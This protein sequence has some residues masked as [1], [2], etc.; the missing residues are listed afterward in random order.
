MAYLSTQWYC[1]FSTSAILYRFASPLYIGSSDFSV[2][3]CTITHDKIIQ[4]SFMMA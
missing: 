3:D 1:A 4:V 2:S